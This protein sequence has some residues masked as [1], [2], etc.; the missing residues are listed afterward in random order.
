MRMMEEAMMIIMIIMEGLPRMELII[1]IIMI[2][3]PQMGHG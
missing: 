2:G 1:G 3:L